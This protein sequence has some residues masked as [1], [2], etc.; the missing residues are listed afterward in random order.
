MSTKARNTLACT[1]CEGTFEDADFYRD[2]SQKGRRG[3]SP[4]CKACEKSYN[5]AYRTGLKEAD[6]SKV[7]AIASD[8]GLAVYHEAMIG[9]RVARKRGTT[10]KV[11][12]ASKKANKAAKAGKSS[13]K[14]KATTKARKAARKAKGS[15]KA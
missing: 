11:E 13:A 14:A 15:T 8:D 4:W 1:K 5:R 6:A 2:K 12:R 10:N 9:E 3:R 7:A